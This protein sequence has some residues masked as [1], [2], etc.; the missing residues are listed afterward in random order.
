MQMCMRNYK[1]R[2]QGQSGKVPGMRLQKPWPKTQALR[3]L[4]QT[5]PKR[6]KKRLPKRQ[7]DGEINLRRVC[8]IH[9]HLGLPLLLSA[10]CLDQI[11]EYRAWIM[12]SV[13]SGPQ[14]SQRR[15][16]QKQ[17]CGLLLTL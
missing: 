7:S 13:S 8:V 10:Y 2:A 5:I 1:E 3:S 9:Q 4:V 6:T 14:T 11:L 16:H 15:L 17:L 12:D